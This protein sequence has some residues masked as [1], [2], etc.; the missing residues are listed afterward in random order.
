MIHKSNK[1]VK[2]TARHSDWQSWFFITG[3]R[4]RRRSSGGQ[5][6]TVTWGLKMARLQMSE[7]LGS[8]P[9]HIE[10]QR[11]RT[12]VVVKLPADDDKDAWVQK[13]NEEF[14]SIWQ[15]RAAV[16]QVASSAMSER[17]VTIQACDGKR[18]EAFMVYGIWIDPQDGSSTFDVGFLPELSDENHVIVK[19][20]AGGTLTTR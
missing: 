6:L 4:F 20:T 12:I 1:S 7:A 8:F 9:T 14:E 13:A 18:H 11:D 5:P 10:F 2:E 16:I 3:K 17:L 15:A 19:R